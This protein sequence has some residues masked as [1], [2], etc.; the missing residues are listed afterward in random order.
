MNKKEDVVNAARELFQ[1][2]GYKRVTMD[3]IA[4]KSNVT[5]KTIYTYFKDKD[6]L[7]KYFLKEEL[8]KMKSI[9]E[10]IEKENLSFDLKIHK[11]ISTLLEYRKEEKLLH[12]FTEEAKNLPS[13]VAKEC[14]D[15]VNETIITEIKNLLEKAIQEKN[16]K[17]CN[18]ELTSFLIYKIY[19]ALIFEWDKPIDKSEVTDSLMQFLKYGL[20]N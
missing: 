11:I 8:I 16:V 10:Q 14:V 13:S 19:V 7:I 15:K 20:F 18:T 17:Q 6:D 5:K 2:Y 12:F 3:E 1:T 9:I 4:K